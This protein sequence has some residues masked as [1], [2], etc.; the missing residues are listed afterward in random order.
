MSLTLDFSGKTVLVVGGTSGINLGIACGFARQGAR[1]AVAS[2]DP[3]KVARAITVLSGL[4][5]EACGVI[6]SYSIH[7]T[8]LYESGV[9][10]PAFTLRITR[11]EK[12]P[13]PSGCVMRTGCLASDR[14]ATGEV[15]GS[16][17]FSPVSADT[18]RA[19]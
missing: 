19:T 6:T 11:P 1:L 9:G 15:S 4:G 14:A 12:R 17:S 2:R 16:A 18:S 13:Q 3:H 8:K 10:A 7:Y 5:S